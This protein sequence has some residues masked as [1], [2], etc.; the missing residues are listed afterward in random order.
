KASNSDGG[1]L[2]GYSLGLSGDGST[3]VAAGY[4]EDGSSRQVNGIPDN[5]RGGSGCLYVFVRENGVW[6][7]QAYLKASNAEG[8]D[9]LGYSAA[10]SRDGNTIAGGAADEDCLKPGINIEGCDADQRSDQSSGAA[11]VFVRENGNWRQ[12]AFIKASNP[13]QNDNFGARIG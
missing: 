9:S 6:R 12:Q 8:G 1:D 10:I 2:F 7:Q 3:M 5:L 11:Y 4:D 13:G